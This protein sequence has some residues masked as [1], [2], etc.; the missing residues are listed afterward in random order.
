MK[1]QH[2]SIAIV[3]ATGAVGR[4]ALAILA[5]RGVPAS[6]VVALASSSSAGRELPYAESTVIVQ[7]LTRERLHACAHAIFAA[8]APTAHQYAPI[9]A[10]HGVFVVDNS[11]AFR[12]HPAVPLVIP[13]V[14]AH[15]LASKPRLVANPNCSTIILLT[16]LQ[17]LRQLA[18]IA[19]VVVSTYQ[20]VSGAGL[21]AVGELYSQSRAVLNGTPAEPSVFPV[22]CAFNVFPHESPTDPATGR[23]VEEQKMI[24][25]SGRIWGIDQAPVLPTC[26]RVPVER[27]HSQSITVLTHQPTTVASVR[28]AL[29]HAPG[30]RLIDDPVNGTFPTPLDASGQDD[31]LVGRIRVDPTGHRVSL[32][33]CG[34]QLRK[35]AALNAV[36]ILDL[37]STGTL[38]PGAMVR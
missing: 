36:Q 16:A 30:V 5:S 19:D 34:D 13:E 37:L 9:A 8:D 25:E 20:A 14:N 28:T 6:R 23:N 17:P 4:E 2:G 32:W 10:E 29:E 21:A 31:I 3:G 26:V 7:E 12:M 22:R 27:A 1:M 33:V 18:G 15:L 35:G 38:T 24:A 11:S